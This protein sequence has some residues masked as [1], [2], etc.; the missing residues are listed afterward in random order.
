[1][2]ASKL[3]LALAAAA[4][5]AALGASTPA[6]ALD[7]VLNDVGGVTGSQAELGFKIAAHYWE[8]RLTNAATVNLDV[9]YSNLG[10]GILGSTGSS[11]AT[12][13]PISGYY[14]ALAATQTSALDAIAVA[15][16]SPLSPTGSVDVLVPAY[17]SPGLGINVA[18]G[19]RTAPDG[20]EISNTMALTTANLKAFGVTLAPGFVDGEIQFSNTFAF[21]F[22]PTN[23]ISAGTYDFIGVAIHEIGH[24]LGFVSGADDFDFADGYTGPVDDAWWGYG[25]DMF[26][27]GA[28]GQLDWTPGTASYFSINGGVSPLMDGFFSTGVF[29]GDGNQASHW[30]EPNQATP[31]NNF[32]GVM[33]PYIC[34]GKEDHVSALD[35]AA[36]DAIGWNVDFDVLE[37]SG[38]NEGSASIYRNF[39]GVPEPG[40]WGLMILGFGLAGFGLRRR[41]A[42][43][44]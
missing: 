44:A 33:N 35:L 19:K 13:V 43:L 22:D 6:S 16:L 40:T 36:F 5:T 27:Y 41:R 7:I 23:G 32:R 20:L 3:R 39:F 24:A 18:D 42:A 37:H 12:F 10:P 30:K 31:C 11:L 28:P 14:G 15:N 8:T 17:T 2:S 34:G 25:L 21:D 26:R 29:N 1:M 9:G 4:A 38:Y